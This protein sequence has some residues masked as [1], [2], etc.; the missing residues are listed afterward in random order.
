MNNE[1]LKRISGEDKITARDV[2]EKSISFFAHVKL[3]MCTNFIPPISA[4]KSTKDRIRYI[5]FDT[6]FSDKP[7][8]NEIKRDDKF[9]EKLKN[10]YLDEVFTFLLNGSIEYY[11][12]R[13]ITP[14]KEWAY[15]TKKII[16]NEDSIE[17]FLKNCVKKTDNPKDT[18]MRKQFFESYQS[19]CNKNSQRC[20][21]RSSL[22]T[23]LD[24]S[25]YRTAK[26]NGYDIYRNIKCT[27][28]DNNDNNDCLFING[29]YDNGVDEIKINQDTKD[30]KIALLENQVKLLINKLKDSAD[31]TMLLNFCNLLDKHADEFVDQEY[32]GDEDILDE[33]EA[34]PIADEFEADK[35]VDDSLF[36]D[37]HV[38]KNGFN[39]NKTT[40]LDDKDTKCIIDNIFSDF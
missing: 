11:K 7:K 33:F 29:S 22:F 6:R 21:S 24:Q 39:K 1:L 23:R 13:K 16:Q 18:I 2:Y 30:K 9:V 25:G 32:D 26:L 37:K 15:R 14:P 3:M 20:Q 34:D 27:Y 17:N 35:V 4:E 36:M 12:D 19:F 40:E 8:N 28:D 38:P 10:D 5:F 31:K